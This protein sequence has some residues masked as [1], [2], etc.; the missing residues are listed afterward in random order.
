MLLGELI[1]SPSRA[2]NNPGGNSRLA[3]DPDNN[4]GHATWPGVGEIWELPNNLNLAYQIR[5]QFAADTCQL[6]IHMTR[7][8]ENP[9]SRELRRDNAIGWGAEMFTT[10]AF[11]TYNGGPWG[12]EGDGGVRGWAR[13]GQAADEN[14][15]NEFFNR[16]QEYT[17]RPHTQGVIIPRSIPNIMHCRVR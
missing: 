7:G 13:N 4:V 3:L 9:V 10:L 5:D 6:D 17:G 8:S 15:V 11:N 16:I 1:T 2:L 14:L 12:V